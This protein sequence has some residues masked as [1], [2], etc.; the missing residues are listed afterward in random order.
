MQLPINPSHAHNF[1]QTHGRHVIQRAELCPGSSSSDTIHG[2]S[3]LSSVCYFS[4]VM[5]G[6]S[7]SR[8]RFGYNPSLVVDR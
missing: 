8:E 7:Q 4:A 1:H 5:P 6:A 2:I 3:L